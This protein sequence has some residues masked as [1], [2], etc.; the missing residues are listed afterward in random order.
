MDLKKLL[1]LMVLIILFSSNGCSHFK[2][3][4]T[5]VKRPMDRTDISV[6]A[7]IQNVAAMET[8]ANYFIEIEFVKGSAILSENAKS[9]VNSLINEARRHGNIDE[10]IVL[11]WSDVEYPS[12]NLKKL[13]TQQRLLAKKRNQAV[14]KYAKDIGNIDVET[15]NMAEKPNAIA[16]LLDTEDNR[17]KESLLAAGLPTTANNPPDASKASHSL[18]LVKLK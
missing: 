11:S 18:I 3:K 17:L 8:Q 10:L 6:P 9:S 12:K 1:K 4:V 14:K 13:S 16:K 5:E 7:S 15:Y 2:S